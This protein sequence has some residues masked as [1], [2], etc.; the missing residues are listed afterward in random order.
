MRDG[1]HKP[2]GI[3]VMLNVVGL[4]CSLKQSPAISNTEIMMERVIDQMRGHTHINYD[5]IRVADYDVKLGVE[6]DE[7]DGDEWPEISRRVLAADVLILGAPIWVG[8]P[9]SVAQRVCERMDSYLFNFNEHG[10]KLPYNRVAGVCI[11]G[12]EDGGHHAFAELAQ[13]LIDFG[14]TLPPEARA[15]WTGWS[16]KSPGPN[17]A[18]AGLDCAYTN[19]MI[20]HMANSL[21]HVATILKEHPIPPLPSDLEQAEVQQGRSAAGFT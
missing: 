2:D 15:Y 18:D 13:A 4:G 17:Y 20:E 9:S 5:P 19:G 11:T 1:N 10:Q 3:D 8:H 7:G 14:F 12:N 16:D 6:L 21:V